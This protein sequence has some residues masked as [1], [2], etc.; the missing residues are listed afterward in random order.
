MI[1]KQFTDQTAHFTAAAFVVVIAS[2]LGATFGPASGAAVG[3]ALGVI[4]EISESDPVDSPFDVL[5]VLFWTLGGLF[6][7]VIS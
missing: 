1:R 6:V 2:V 5:D 4:R 7:G 3:F